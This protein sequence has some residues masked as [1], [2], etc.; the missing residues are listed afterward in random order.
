MKATA[1]SMAASRRLRR[2]M[3]LPEALLWRLLRRSPGG[4]K[5]RRQHAIGSF[6]ADFYCP[7]AKLVIE[8]DGVAHDMGDRP[9]RD[10]ARDKWLTNEG[11]EVLRI[12]AREILADPDAVADALVKLCADRAGP[13]HHSPSASGP[14]PHELCSQGG[15]QK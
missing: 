8:I 3:S 14:P 15:S 2:N 4:I 5:F 10:E 6:V 9:Q 11:L 13:L 7:A 12:A 1:N